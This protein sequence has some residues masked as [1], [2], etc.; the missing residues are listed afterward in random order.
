M[1]IK[2]DAPGG[3]SLG[4]IPCRPKTH[5]FRRVA[6]V[7]WGDKNTTTYDDGLI[8]KL[9]KNEQFTGWE[10]GR[11]R[12]GKSYGDVTLAIFQAIPL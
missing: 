7:R 4:Y 3:R 9:R 5:Y 2:T 12:Q 10:W 1:A 6:I 8:L 11:L